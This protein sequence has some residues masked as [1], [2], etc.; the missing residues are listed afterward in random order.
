[1]PRRLAKRSIARNDP[2]HLAHAAA[3]AARPLAGLSQAATLAWDDA[4]VIRGA[5]GACSAVLGNGPADLRGIPLGSLFD[6]P[7]SL[8]DALRFGT[9]RSI[10]L[11]SGSVVRLEAGP[12]PGGAVGIFRSP[13]ADELDLTRLVSAL[14]HE[15]RN[16]FASVMLAVQSLGKQ[17]EVSTERGR[18]RLVV[19]ERELRRIECVLRGLQEIGRSPVGRPTDTIPERLIGDAVASLG[20]DPAG[21]EVTIRAPVDPGPAAFLDPPRVRLALEEMIRHGVRS[22][23]SA[24]SVEITVERR[25]AEIALLILAASAT[26]V[27]STQEEEARGDTVLGLAVAEGVA[28]AHGGHLEVRQSAGRCRLELVVP[29]HNR[30]VA[31]GPPPS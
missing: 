17:G 16:A 11:C 3:A 19:A 4:L 30:A 14:G 25:P 20:P 7:G 24:G 8:A 29:Q 1:M 2:S 31:A 10:R 26:E 21:P 18:R 9:A 23:G 13:T 27:E 22:V 5:A 28:R 15:L 12:C 6:K